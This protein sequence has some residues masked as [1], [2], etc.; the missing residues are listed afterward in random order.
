MSLLKGFGSI[1]SSMQNFFPNVIGNEV[2][3]KLGHAL[4]ALRSLRDIFLLPWHGHVFQLVL[5]MKSFKRY[6]VS[7]VVLSLQTLT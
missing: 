4:R 7:Q 6:V 1:V 3:D 5:Y 2:C